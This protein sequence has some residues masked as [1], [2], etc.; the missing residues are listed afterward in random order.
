MYLT[1]LFRHSLVIVVLAAD[2]MAQQAPGQSPSS[3][4]E[5]SSK[6]RNSTVQAPASSPAA[7]S[8]SDGIY[9]NTF[10]GFRYKV[11][12]GWVDRTQEMQQ[13]SEAGQPNASGRSLVLLAVFERPPQAAGEGVNSA[14]VIAAE[15]ASSYPGLKAAADYLGP[16]TEVTTSKGFKAAGEPYEFA[17]GARQLV[18]ADFSKDLGSLTMRQSTLVWLQK[19]YVVSFS[20]IGGTEDEIEN[21]IEGLSFGASRPRVRGQSP[22]PH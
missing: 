3:R 5:S 16:L 2:C 10:F 18:R 6:T 15:S 19:G 4:T 9:R 22:A 1:G 17:V 12:F 7:G 8:L 14:V 13:S 21:L 20:F 11:P